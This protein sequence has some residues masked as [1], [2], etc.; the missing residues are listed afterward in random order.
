[1]ATHTKPRRGAGAS[2]KALA[3]QLEQQAAAF[4][5]AMSRSD[6]ASACIAAQ[7]A[8]KIMP[9]HMGVLSDYAFCLMRLGQYEQA[10]TVY[11]R[12]YALPSHLQQQA[13]PTW[14]DGLAEVCGWL[15]RTDD[16]RRYGQESLQKADAV[17]GR[18]AIV[19]HLKSSPPAFDSTAP[20]RNV[21]AF[22]LFGDNPRYCES[23]VANIEV[24]AQLFPDWRCRVYLDNSVP[25]SVE[26]RL[27]KAGAQVFDMSGAAG[28]GVHPLM[29]R[30]LVIDDP[31]VDRYLIR[32]ADALLS[33]RE[34]AAVD[35]WVASP[36]WFH[37]IRDYF[38]HTELILA[39]LWG[40]CR[41]GLPAMKPLMQAWMARQTNVTR[42]VDQKFL[43]EVVWPSLRQSVM[44]HD[45][46]FDFHGARPFPAHAPIRW[47][48][49]KFHVGSNASF[50]GIEGTTAKAE[51]DRQCWVIIDGQGQERCRYHARVI[52]GRWRADL[53]F[54]MIEPIA[55]GAWRVVA[56]D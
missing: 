9:Q 40:G 25:G 16:V 1:M 4:R 20:E 23:A 51:G 31:D 38:T 53:P 26:L 33:E 19:E 44:C 52:A 6:H 22:T 54:F 42:F 49:D 8:L 7:A 18:G 37:H 11:R 55:S 10:H 45:E 32:D 30:N 34:K 47:R 35:E 15:E 12:I 43:R 48:T 21:I 39:G 29:W 24:A 17:H 3:R 36:N 2:H 13:S 46:F 41:G 27:R 5:A 56:R 14:L 50:Q 28:E